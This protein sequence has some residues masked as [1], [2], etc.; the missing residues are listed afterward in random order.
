MQA[1]L[2]ERGEHARVP[3]QTPPVELPRWQPEW[4]KPV[5]YAVGDMALFLTDVGGTTVCK[6]AHVDYGVNPPQLVVEVRPH[7]LQHSVRL[8]GSLVK[9][10]EQSTLTC[11]STP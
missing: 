9:Q 10:R 11:V 5:A 7:S 6:V 3:V 4:G 2:T 8:V 1:K